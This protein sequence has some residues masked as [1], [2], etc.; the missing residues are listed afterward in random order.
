VRWTVIMVRVGTTRGKQTQFLATSREPQMSTWVYGKSV[1][2]DCGP[3]VVRDLH[4]DSASRV[5]HGYVIALALVCPS[6]CPCY[7]RAL[8]W[9]THA[10]NDRSLFRL[11]YPEHHYLLSIFFSHT[12]PFVLHTNVL[13]T[14]PP[15]GRV[16]CE[17]Y[18]SC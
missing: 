17:F 4:V 5:G 6:D 12:S 13:V 18:V 3:R 15:C 11:L 2:V 9:F 8:S 1:F 10:T 14:V 7:P 16:S